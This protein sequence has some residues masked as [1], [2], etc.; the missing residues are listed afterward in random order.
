MAERYACALGGE[1]GVV[2]VL[3]GRGEGAG[4]WPGAGD[5]GDVVAVLLTAN[6]NLYFR[7][8]GLVNKDLRRLHLQ[9]RDRCPGEHRH[10]G[11]SG[12]DSRSAN[13]QHASD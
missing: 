11:R 4:N 7:T 1:D 9:E 8:C 12:F 6:V 5:V 10:S 3:L 13:S 2:E